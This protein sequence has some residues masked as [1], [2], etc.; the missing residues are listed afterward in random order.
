MALRERDDVHGAHE[1][2][3]RM[4]SAHGQDMAPSAAATAAAATL[5]TIASATTNLR[6]IEMPAVNHDERKHPVEAPVKDVY[7]DAR[8]VSTAPAS[9]YMTGVPSPLH[10][11]AAVNDMFSLSSSLSS[12]MVSSAQPP[13]SPGEPVN[14]RRSDASRGK[15]DEAE[16]GRTSVRSAQHQEET[17]F[18]S[19]LCRRLRALHGR[20]GEFAEENGYVR[21]E[22]KEVRR[23]SVAM[24]VG[25]SLCAK[26]FTMYG[27]KFSPR[28]MSWRTPLQCPP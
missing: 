9:P 24:R 18:S 4:G 1:A 5:P 19:I 28:Q 7:R 2:A 23:S 27:H 26:V 3:T 16:G 25:R 20:Y 12:P 22:D 21:C 14:G 17:R 13:W 6:P 11:P 10:S 8:M 15:E